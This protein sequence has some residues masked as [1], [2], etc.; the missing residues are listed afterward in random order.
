[1][2][3]LSVTLQNGEHVRM[4]VK[5]AEFVRECPYCKL[6]GEEFVEFLT[7]DPDQIYCKPSHRVNYCRKTR[8]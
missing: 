3:T 4:T 8:L 7:I 6:I 5:Q 2:L 1:M